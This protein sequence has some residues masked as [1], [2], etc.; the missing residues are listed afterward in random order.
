MT[1]L[2]SAI[3][4]PLVPWFIRLRFSPNAITG[5]SVLF[6]FLSGGF[7][8]FGTPA[9]A[10]VGAACFLLSNVLDECDGQVARKTNRSSSLGALLDTLADSLVH[11]AFFFGLG[12]GMSRQFPQGPWFFLGAAAA[13]GSVLSCAMDVGGITPWQ[14]P[15]PT[16]KSPEGFLAGLIEWLR[17]DFSMVVVISAVVRQMGWILWSGALGVFLFWIP[18]TVLIA[19]RG[20]VK[21][22]S[23]NRHLEA[24]TPRH[25][26]APKVP[27]NLA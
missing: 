22:R 10:M 1:P 7:L 8:A 24:P 13:G 21:G 4:R 6:G 12:V 20:R 5:L 3:A 19:A 27:R 23:L 18:S 9:A 15:K 26:E 14:P 25:F 2:N 11:A 17:I 16:D